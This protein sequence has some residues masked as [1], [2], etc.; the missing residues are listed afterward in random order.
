MAK[1]II[2]IDAETNGLWGR[3]FAIAAVVYSEEGNELERF[4]ARCSIEEEVN[5]WVASNVLPEMEAI[6]TTHESYEAMLQTFGEWWLA[7]KEGAEA[8]WHMGHVVEAFLFREMHRVGAIGDWDA[9][10]T[11]IEVAEMLRNGGYAADSVD[12]YLEAKGLPKP[13]VEGGTHNPLYDCMVAAEVY[14]DLVK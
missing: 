6:P 7:N 10:Y 5:P 2:S 11:P 1:K 8:L 3:P 13:Q 9:P 4:V 12:S 14:F